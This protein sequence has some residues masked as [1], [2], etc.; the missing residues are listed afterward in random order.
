MSSSFRGPADVAKV[1]TDPLLQPLDVR[2]LSSAFA[3]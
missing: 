1:T 3:A 2:E